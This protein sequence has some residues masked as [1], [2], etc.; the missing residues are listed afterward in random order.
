MQPVYPAGGQIPPGVPMQPGG[1]VLPPPPPAP[2]SIPPHP[3]AITP[4]YPPHV[5]AQVV[6]PPP[7]PPASFMVQPVPPPQFPQIAPLQQQQQPVVVP[8]PTQTQQPLT[9]LSRAPTAASVRTTATLEPTI[10]EIQRDANELK[11]AVAAVVSGLNE[12]EL[13]R[14]KAIDSGSVVDLQ[15]VA[16]LTTSTG[17]KIGELSQPLASV[18]ERTETLGRL[19]KEGRAAATMMEVNIVNEE[20]EVVKIHVMKAVEQVRGLAL[21]ES[22]ALPA[23]RARLEAKIKSE[24]PAMTPDMVGLSVR[25]AEAGKSEKI[26]QLDINSYSGFMAAQMP[27]TEL[28]VLLDAIVQQKESA[29]AD[30]ASLSGNTMVGSEY[31][32]FDNDI[33]LEHAPLRGVGNNLPLDWNQV[34][35][36]PGLIGKIRDNWRDYLL[37]FFLVISCLGIIVGLITYETIKAADKQSN[38][39]TST[40]TEMSSKARESPSVLVKLY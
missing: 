7:P 21:E 37:R 16:D 20:L 8:P 19:A 15:A 17:V 31:E 38:N 4:V 22:D 32:K 36:N 26:S 28:S 18:R 40:T 12:L 9:T 33:D 23:T 29:E 2:A 39:S 11:V 35:R 24:N 14:D 5:P 1:F 34:K 25:Q 27:F 6:L 3:Q 30:A 13:K 10:D